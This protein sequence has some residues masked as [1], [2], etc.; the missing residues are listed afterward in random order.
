MKT[1]FIEPDCTVEFNGQ[2]FTSGGA[3]VSDSHIIAY[4]AECGI[5]NDWHGNKIGTYRVISRRLA[6]FFG[7]PSWQGSHYYFMRARVNGV[8]YSLRGFGVGMIATGKRV[9]S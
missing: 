8:T 7:R 9:K 3:F 2:K 4:P 5:L 6:I 1:P